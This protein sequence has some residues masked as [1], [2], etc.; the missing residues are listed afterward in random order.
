MKE[1]AF[2]DDEEEMESSQTSRPPS[3]PPFSPISA[4]E[5]DNTTYY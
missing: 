1:A 5:Q 4:P 2:T 3:K